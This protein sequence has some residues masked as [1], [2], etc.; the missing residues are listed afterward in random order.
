M[1]E[2]NE[3][4]GE[5]VSLP[6]VPMTY[7]EQAQKIT[8]LKADIDDL[9]KQIINWRNMHDRLE[10]KIHSLTTWLE[11]NWDD[12]TETELSE[13]FQEIADIFGIDTEVSKEVTVDVRYRLT[14]TA[15][16]G[17]DWSELTEYAFDVTDIESDS[18]EF[19]VDSCYYDIT[20]IEVD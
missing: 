19:A 12:D 5:S 20:D 3:N 7:E 13:A 18:S 8:N 2:N 6:E 14:V 10:G 1:Y 11:N 4:N 15:K 17:T 9:S 16:R